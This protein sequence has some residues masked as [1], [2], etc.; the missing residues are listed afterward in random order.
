MHVEE[1]KLNH[2][3]KRGISVLSLLIFMIICSF[4][5]IHILLYCHLSTH[6]VNDD[7]NIE[8]KDYNSHFGLIIFHEKLRKSDWCMPR[9]KP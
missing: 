3:R 5:K 2:W 8:Q 4:L 6:S 7:P 1:I 9:V